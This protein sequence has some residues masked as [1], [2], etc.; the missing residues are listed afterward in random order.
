MQIKTHNSN[1][2]V[3]T[4]TTIS[5]EQNI[6]KY[7]FQK[8]YKTHIPF[9]NTCSHSNHPHNPPQN[10]RTGFPPRCNHNVPMLPYSRGK[11]CLKQ[12]WT[13]MRLSA[14]SNPINK[15]KRNIN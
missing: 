2:K 9:P 3:Q 7:W 1:F 14:T 6:S 13:A 8:N 5:T 4:K 15:K 10:L 12:S 11:H